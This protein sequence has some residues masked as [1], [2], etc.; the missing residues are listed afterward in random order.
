MEL[1][2]ELRPAKHAAKHVHDI[3]QISIT[4]CWK[5]KSDFSDELHC[6]L[7]NCEVVD[8]RDMATESRECEAVAIN[9]TETS[10]EETQKLQTSSCPCPQE[11][12]KAK[13]VGSKVEL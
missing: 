4:G 7:W 9:Q 13:R 1:N 12:P 10:P 5:K 6:L 11:K 8:T 2:Q 3:V